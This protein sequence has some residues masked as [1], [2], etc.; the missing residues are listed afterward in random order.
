MDIL[1][2]NEKSIRNFLELSDKNKQ[3]EF[4]YI[5]GSKSDTLTRDDFLK[6]I[7]YCKNNYTY[8]DSTSSLDIKLDKSFNSPLIFISL[9]LFVKY[10]PVLSHITYILF[11]HL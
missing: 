7:D 3:I 4:E 9:F 2:I 1:K 5:F 10:H 6:C 8:I 11:L